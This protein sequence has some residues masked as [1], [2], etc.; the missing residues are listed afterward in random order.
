MVINLTISIVSSGLYRFSFGS[1]VIDIKA[2][3][4]IDAKTSA[5]KSIE[6]I[7]NTEMVRLAESTST[8]LN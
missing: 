5:M 7:M 8:M 4:L 3:N 1:Y 2:N 6:H